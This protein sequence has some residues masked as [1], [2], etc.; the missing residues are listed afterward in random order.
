MQ[1]RMLPSSPNALKS[2]SMSVTYKGKT[3]AICSEGQVAYL[4][5]MALEKVA[6]EAAAR[7]EQLDEARMAEA[8]NRRVEERGF[9][10]LKMVLEKMTPAEQKQWA[11]R[12]RFGAVS[13][14]RS[15]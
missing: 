1:S 15:N 5:R 8:V 3:Y 4:R 13:S 11:A 7:G 10:T 12:Y 9:A 6:A 2:Q 14:A